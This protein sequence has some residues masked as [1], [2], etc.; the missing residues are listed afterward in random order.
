M[1][2]SRFDQAPP[3][4]F[5]HGEEIGDHLARATQVASNPREV[6]LDLAI[7]PPA[8]VRY[9][10]RNRRKI[11]VEMVKI[12]Y[13]L[14]SGKYVFCQIRQRPDVDGNANLDLRRRWLEVES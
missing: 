14:R 2:L 11:K 13:L 6:A 8:K 9:C 3:G 1:L 7:D 4:E 10:I 5:E 12:G